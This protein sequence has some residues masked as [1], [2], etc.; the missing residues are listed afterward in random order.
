MDPRTSAY[1]PAEYRCRGKENDSFGSLAQV[2]MYAPPGAQYTLPF[3]AQ[4]HHDAEYARD[5]P[6]RNAAPPPRNDAAPRSFGG[7]LRRA[8]ETLCCLRDTESREGSL[9]LEQ[10]PAEPG[11]DY[12]APY[13]SE[14][15]V[16][17]GEASYLP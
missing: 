3:A 17:D 1:G 5:P 13:Y 16:S 8:F 12:H 7:S 2:K 15:E 6:V 11:Y 14:Q 4:P 9:D 10:P